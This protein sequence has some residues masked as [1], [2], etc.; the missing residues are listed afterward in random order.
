MFNGC[1][2]KDIG[3]TLMD[4]PLR[5]IL[6]NAMILFV[7]M[8]LSGLMNVLMILKLVTI[9]GVEDIVVLSPS[10][11]LLYLNT[12]HQSIGLKWKERL[13]ITGSCNSCKQLTDN[14]NS[15]KQLTNSYNSCEQLTSS[16]DCSELL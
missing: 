16:Y 11:E 1:Y 10:S 9:K 7:I 15:C 13:T 12:R 6:S 3:G 8:N 4:S 5:P 2:Y 14:Y